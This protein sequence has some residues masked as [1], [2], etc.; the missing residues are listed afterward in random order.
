V[1]LSFSA[2]DP[3]GVKLRKQGQIFAV[4][5]SSIVFANNAANCKSNA[6]SKIITFGNGSLS[7]LASASQFA[8]FKSN[9][10]YT[11]K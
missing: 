7:S 3:R 8:I 5:S 9:G 2:I 10:N 4:C 11:K 1:K 6:A